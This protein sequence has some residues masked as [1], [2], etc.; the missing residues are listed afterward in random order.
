MFLQGRSRLRAICR[1]GFGGSNH[2]VPDPK[3]LHRLLTSAV[4]DFVRFPVGSNARLEN[5]ALA[6][7]CGNTVATLIVRKYGSYPDRR[8]SAG[9]PTRAEKRHVQIGNRSQRNQQ[10]RDHV[11]QTRK[12]K[13]SGVLPPKTTRN[14]VLD[15][16]RPV[17]V[18]GSNR[19]KLGDRAFISVFFQRFGGVCSICP[20]K[21]PKFARSRKRQIARS[22]ERP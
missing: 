19:P 21:P 18:H 7:T 13:S 22:R 14:F 9:S 2:P 15:A 1:F 17:P 10:S 6:H 8:R 11:R 16:K 4:S 20:G 12:M 3:F 5:H